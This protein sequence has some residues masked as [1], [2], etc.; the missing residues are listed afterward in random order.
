MSYL[1]LKT[2]HQGA[3]ILSVTGFAVRGLASFGGGGWVRGRA[4][5][6]LPHVIDT[7]LLGSALSMAV[8]ARW[9]PLEQPWLAAKLV[10][11]VAYIALGRVALAPAR[12]L[13]TRVAAWAAA[14]VT[15]AYI[16]S[17]ALHKSALG[18]LS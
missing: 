17:V 14:L 16:V 4:A 10:A 7:V 11:L 15:V 5:R 3:V 8:I 18:F 2:V 1:L 6:T 12:P 13:C 9:N